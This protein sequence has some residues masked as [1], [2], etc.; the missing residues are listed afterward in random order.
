VAT[1]SAVTRRND[2]TLQCRVLLPGAVSTDHPFLEQRR[3]GRDAISR[4]CI[5]LHLSSLP[6]HARAMVRSLFLCSAASQVD[7]RNCRQV[8]VCH[9]LSIRYRPWKQFLR[10]YLCLPSLR[11]AGSGAAKYDGC[12]TF[13][14]V[15]P[16]DCRV[17][18]QPERYRYARGRTLFSLIRALTGGITYNGTKADP[19]FN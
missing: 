10:Y 8:S 6:A 12:I 2:T 18:M 3:C 16:R 17:R 7:K 1:C 4:A 9:C 11:D 5:T 19:W 15:E 13:R 14:L